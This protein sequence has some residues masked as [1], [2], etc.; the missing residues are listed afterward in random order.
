MSLNS[1]DVFKTAG[2]KGC[3][4]A[5]LFKLVQSHVFHHLHHDDWGYVISIPSKHTR[6]L[7]MNREGARLNGREELNESPVKRWRTELNDTATLEATRSLSILLMTRCM[8]ALRVYVF[9]NRSYP[10]PS[11][12]GENSKR[13]DPVEHHGMSPIPEDVSQIDHLKALGRSSSPPSTK[14]SDITVFELDSCNFVSVRGCCVEAVYDAHQDLPVATIDAQELRESIG[15]F[16]V[17]IIGR[18]NAG[19]TTILQKV[20]NT[21]DQPEIFDAKGN[22]IDAD[23]VEASIKRGNHNITNEM[24]FKSSPGFVFHDSCGFE[25]GSEEEFESMKRFISERVH[26]TKLEER[27]HAIWQRSEEKFFLECDTGH[28][29]VITVFTK[30]EALRPVAY[31]DIKKEIQG[32]SAEERSKRIAQRVE[33]LFANT[34]VC[35]RLCD[36][37]NRTRPKFHVR[38]EM[39]D[40]DMNKPNTNCNTLLERTTF[41]LDNDELRLCL[42][43]TQQS[44]LELCIKCAVATLVDRAHQQS[45]LR[46]VDYEV[47]QYAIAK[48]FAHLQLPIDHRCSRPVLMIRIPRCCSPVDSFGLSALIVSSP[49]P[50]FMIPI[51]RCYSPVDSDESML[52]IPISRCCS[53]VD[54]GNPRPVLMILIPRCCSH[55]DRMSEYVGALIV[56]EP[57]PVSIIPIPRRCS[58]VDRWG[59]V[60]SFSLVLDLCSSS[61]SPVAARLLTV[62]GKSLDC[63]L[64]YDPNVLLPPACRQKEVADND[65][66]AKIRRSDIIRVLQPLVVKGSMFTSAA[67]RIVQ[68]GIAT[69]I[70]LEYSAFLADDLDD[71]KCIESAMEYYLK[72]PTAVVVEKGA[73]EISRQGYDAEELEKKIL[74]FILENR[75]YTTLQSQL[76]NAADC[77]EFQ[78]PFF[79]SNL[80]PSNDPLFILIFNNDKNWLV[81]F[82]AEAEGH[83][84]SQH[85]RCSSGQHAAWGREDLGQKTKMTESDTDVSRH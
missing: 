4:H 34:G 25:A 73:Q 31:G 17:L 28:V 3:S 9:V 10:E 7:P 65:L 32:V 20:C 76:L 37:E 2:Y 5:Y 29:P 55:V 6:E 61:P 40:L 67:N 23:V 69:V 24:V 70:V 80:R 83:D 36:P 33:E 21:T 16:R 39:T 54:R 56:S 27:I 38:L 45:G 52:V 1:V 12:S 79:G 66:K 78:H 82:N 53:P 42:V 13:T 49:R 71:L 57:R 72:S 30:F 46:R 77:I 47:N 14:I 8:P 50:T 26:A 84:G 48:W 51:H 18:A 63:F 11:S 22:R 19:K 58:P 64:T 62:S 41:A 85:R 35:D 75:L 74:E 81:C 15:R 68:T 44:N 59:S 43:S 60:P